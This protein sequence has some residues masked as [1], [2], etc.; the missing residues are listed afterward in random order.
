MK[1][2]PYFYDAQMKRQLVQ[3][4][5]QFYGYQV[6]TGQQ[7]DGKA[8]FRDVHVMY[9]DMSRVASYIFSDGSNSNVMPYIP[10]LAVYDTSMRQA[11][12]Y[13]ITP[14]HVE[15]QYYHSNVLDANGD[16]VSSVRGKPTVV[17]RAQPVPY[18]VDIEVALWASNRDE[19]LQVI[20]QIGSEFNPDK[21]ILLSNSPTDWTAQSTLIFDGEFRQEKARPSGTDADP[22]FVTTMN[23]QTVLY[24]SPPAKVYDMTPI[25]E[26]VV[27]IHEIEENL[28]FSQPIDGLIIKPSDDEVLQFEYNVGAN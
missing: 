14:T 6:M 7:R 5:S 26:I 11:P 9:G 18:Y 1:K 27:P 16:V 28:D 13:R 23:F 22:L 3:I 25:E 12:E 15:Q 20:E 17:E 10:I 19:S 8:R 24:V 21:S 2:K 4:M